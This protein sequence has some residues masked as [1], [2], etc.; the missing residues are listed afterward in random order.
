MHYI[1]SANQNYEWLKDGTIFGL[2]DLGGSTV[3]TAVYRCLSTSP[4]KLVEF[5][6]PGC[7]STPRIVS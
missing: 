1:L 6:S 3:D 7:A 4:L 5:R 2:A